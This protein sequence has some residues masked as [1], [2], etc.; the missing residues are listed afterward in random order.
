[1]ISVPSVVNKFRNGSIILAISLVLLTIFV[2]C[3]SF[4][5]HAL[6]SGLAKIRTMEELPG[7]FT[8]PPGSYQQTTILP[9]ASMD[10][11]WWILHAQ[12][13]LESDSLRI[14]ETPIDNAPSGREVHWSSGL[15]WLIAGLA[16]LISFFNGRPPMDYVTW[17][18]IL[19]P[20]ILLTLSV[21]GIGALVAKRLGWGL[22]G[23]FVLVLFTSRTVH[24]GFVYGMLDHHGIV[25]AFATASVLAVVFAGA[26]LV[27]S[28]KAKFP[29]LLNE[30]SAR[31]WMILAGT[32][33]GAALWVSAA[34]AIP[35][36]AGCG[37]GAIVAAA[38]ARRMGAGIQPQLWRAWGLAGC[39]SSLFFYALEYF[40]SH[41][42]WRLEV[43]HPL[44]ALAWLAASELL[45][46]LI[47]RLFTGGR[48]TSGTP[49]DLL[50]AGLAIA[51]VL[52]PAVMAI[53]RPDLFFYVSDKF[54]LALHK[55]HI[56]EF[57]PLWIFLVA[58]EGAVF[59]IL[60]VF[61][62]PL[63]VLLGIPL[64]L[65][66]KGIS[67]VWRALAFFV[68]CPLLVMQLLAF[69]QIRWQGM[70][71]GL[72]MIEV[73]LLAA[74]TLQLHTLSPLPRGVLT[75]LAALSVIAATWHPQ[76][77]FRNALTVPTDFKNEL[78]KRCA[79]TVLLRDVAHRLLQANPHRIPI[80]LAGPN[81]STD[82]SYYGH[83]HTLGTLYWE[84]VEGLK[85]AAGIFAAPNAQEALSLIQQAGVTHIVVASWD[86]FGMD[87][88]KLL[89]ESGAISEAPAEP[90]VKSL[91]D[92]AEPPFWIRPLYYP[93]PA[94]FG[95]DGAQ[96]RIFAV[97]PNQ[98]PLD[99]LIHRGTYHL[100]AGD[101]EA[102]KKI[103]Q[104]AL[105]TSPDDTRALQGL[106]AAGTLST[107]P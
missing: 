105:E 5:S 25:F 78:P 19:A 56:N 59:Q 34:T 44:H 29:F 38:S 31:R 62:W 27:N 72:W 39:L 52:L 24:E 23:L 89:N 75:L 93:I 96:V 102:A 26:G 57:Q 65:W 70:A 103:F 10:M 28:K 91:L 85:K 15:I 55:E 76:A 48:L 88:V 60:T 37:L 7:S 41:M 97:L 17:A 32:L 80:V 6:I 99:A 68:F 42:G 1:M 45:A 61:V 63:V 71:T 64:L 79:P 104:R 30:A 50:T 107:K 33:G 40:P 81:S 2:F 106:K 98:S 13:L 67:P 8:I 3:E 12:S 54:L 4:F 92:G 66:R 22:A 16:K 87:Y 53:S 90:F 18:A 73:L 49:R 43:N 9:P 11:R 86:D 74:A 100:D 20:L 36:L 51:C 69:S 82:L 58:G 77:V 84:N 47:S 35:V 21:A 14:R 101:S 46:R 95:L 83:I 94:V